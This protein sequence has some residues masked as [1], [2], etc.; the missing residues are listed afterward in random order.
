MQFVAYSLR[1]FSRMDDKTG[2]G[3]TGSTNPA[4]NYLEDLFLLENPFDP[5]EEAKHVQNCEITIVTDA[6][7][8]E[9]NK[10][11]IPKKRTCAVSV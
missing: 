11:R 2:S 1:I 6:E 4:G 7:I 3:C 5:V 8:E 9:Q 10:N